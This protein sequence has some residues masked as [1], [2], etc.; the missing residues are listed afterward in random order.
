MWQTF[1]LKTSPAPKNIKHREITQGHSHIKIV[2]QDSLRAEA[3]GRKS[4]RYLAL[5]S[6]GPEFRV[7]TRHGE[8]ETPL[9]LEDA[10][11]TSHALGPRTKLTSIKT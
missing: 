10:Q 6:S 5:K 1:I 7:F 11:K 2:F 3:A 4:L 8:K 9:L